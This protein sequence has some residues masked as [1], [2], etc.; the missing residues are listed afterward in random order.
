MLSDACRWW[1]AGVTDASPKWCEHD[2]L[3]GGMVRKE[4]A[5]GGHLSEPV[6][7]ALLAVDECVIYPKRSDYIVTVFTNMHHY[8]FSGLWTV[9]D[10][11]SVTASDHATRLSAI[12]VVA[13]TCA[14]RGSAC[15][16]VRAAHR[17]SPSMSDVCIESAPDDR[18]FSFRGDSSGYNSEGDVECFAVAI[19]AL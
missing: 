16:S 6:V 1:D 17:D 19:N 18:R 4:Q 11:S 7:T 14:S 15:R 2:S 3:R 10:E 8:R 12:T 13:R 5:S 9:N